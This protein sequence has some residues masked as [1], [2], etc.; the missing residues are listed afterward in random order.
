MKAQQKQQREGRGPCASRGPLFFGEAFGGLGAEVRADA[1]Y[2]VDLDWAL[3]PEPVKEPAILSKEKPHAMIRET[4]PLLEGFD[5]GDE[6]LAHAPNV[7][8]LACKS[9]HAITFVRGV[10]PSA[11]KLA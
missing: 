11:R 10:C 8:A 5:F 1:L 3:G 9:I 7:H 6:F 2:R 4:G